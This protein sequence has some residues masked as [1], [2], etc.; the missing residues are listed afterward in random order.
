MV[1]FTP[2]D[3]VGAIGGYLGGIEALGRMFGGRNGLFGGR[4]VRD[5]DDGGK[6]HHKVTEHEL[7]LVQKNNYLLSENA[8]LRS[9][10][11]VDNKTAALAARVAELETKLAVEGA[12]LR[13][14]ERF[15][16]A[17]YIHQPKTRI[18]ESIVTCRQGDCDD[19]R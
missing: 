4:D 7:D 12:E 3:R 17:E 15:A 2:A 18:R 8:E 13:D 5:D 6:Y 11:Y 14:F 1:N 19:D 9:E 10:K 16:N